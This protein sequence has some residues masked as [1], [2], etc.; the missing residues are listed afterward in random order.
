M[1]IGLSG[2][3]CTRAHSNMD[4]FLFVKNGYHTSLF[5]FLFFSSPLLLSLCLLSRLKNLYRLE[6]K[7][8]NAKQCVWDVCVLCGACLQKLQLALW[9]SFSHPI[10]V[11]RKKK[12]TNVSISV[13]YLRRK[14][15]CE[16]W[17]EVS[18]GGRVCSLVSQAERMRQRLAPRCLC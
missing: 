13:L 18:L 5:L 10:L 16:V 9:V 1:H 17:K 2:L 14:R 7:L 4:R 3:E 8:S 11:T 12:I 6:L 15:Y